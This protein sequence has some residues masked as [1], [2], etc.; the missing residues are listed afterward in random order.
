MAG[1]SVVLLGSMETYRYLLL[2]AVFTGSLTP[3]SLE[4]RV[5]FFFI[6]NHLARR[7]KIA[8]FSAF[9]FSR[10]F[11]EGAFFPVEPLKPPWTARRRRRRL[12]L[13]QRVRGLWPPSSSL[14]KRQQPVCVCA[15][16]N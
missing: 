13:P 10:L 4:V 12:Q 6:I 16:P 14:L 11:L 7:N 1:V 5:P 15:A 9:A 3:V 8:V 2:D